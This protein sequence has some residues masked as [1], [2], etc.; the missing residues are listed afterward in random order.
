MRVVSAI[1]PI[2]THL[3]PQAL[4]L[5]VSDQRGGG[6]PEPCDL[7]CVW[8]R[9]AQLAASGPRRGAPLVWRPAARDGRTA[10][11][12]SQA[13][14]SALQ[15]RSLVSRGTPQLPHPLPT[16][17]GSPAHPRARRAGNPPPTSLRVASSGPEISRTCRRH[18]RRAAPIPASTGGRMMSP[19]C[20][21]T[22]PSRSRSPAPHFACSASSTA[23]AD[24]CVPA[25]CCA[26][27]TSARRSRRGPQ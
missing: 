25:R 8:A 14:A 23:A 20:T 26:R 12:G 3:P 10:T 21:T 2:A 15:T 24:A 17:I 11:P 22:I 16:G 19:P 27:P 1:S 7:L 9:N 13:E 6:R 4:R 18:V 5:E